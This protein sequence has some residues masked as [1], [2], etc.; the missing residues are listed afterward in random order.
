MT[1]AMGARITLKY[2][3]EILLDGHS[4]G[5]RKAIKIKITKI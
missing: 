1:N 4:L 2:V 3:G 5:I